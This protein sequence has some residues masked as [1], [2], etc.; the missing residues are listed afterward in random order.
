LYPTSGAVS[1]VLLSSPPAPAALLFSSLFPFFHVPW[2]GFFF[3]YVSLSLQRGTLPC[4]NGAIEDQKWEP[5]LRRM[6]PEDG[7]PC[8][9]A[10]R[11]ASGVMR[12][13]MT[14][15]SFEVTSVS[16][17]PTLLRF[18]TEDE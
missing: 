13:T 17:L 4:E 2:S 11:L 6:K 18:P 7:W 1:S 12:R 16:G 15:T 9:L 5:L 3:F 14:S 8:L 10:V